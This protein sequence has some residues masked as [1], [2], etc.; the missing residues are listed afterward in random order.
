MKFSE[1]ET[2]AEALAAPPEP[3]T[4]AEWELEARWCWEDVRVGTLSMV[5][6]RPIFSRSV[7]LGTSSCRRSVSV[8]VDA[9]VRGGEHNAL[10][11]RP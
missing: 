5:A 11:N 3:L 9:D 7:A 10:P 8:L 4:P 6:G 2:I 1:A